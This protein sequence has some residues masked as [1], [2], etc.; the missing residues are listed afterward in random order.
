MDGKNN[1]RYFLMRRFLVMLLLV[2]A[3]EGI[4]N[5]LFH[6]VIYPWAG[7][8]FGFGSLSEDITLPGMVAL[9]LQSLCYLCLGKIAV[10]LPDAAAGYVQAWLSRRMGRNL[11]YWFQEYTSGL[12]PREAKLY[13]VGVVCVFLFVA[14]LWLLPYVAAAVSFGITVSRKVGEIEEERRRQQENYERQRNLLLSDVAHDLK[15]PMT[16]VAGYA[17]AL[18]SGT[19]EDDA[20][21]REYLEAIHRKS[22]QMNDLLILLFEYVKLDSEGFSLKK[23]ETDIVELLRE[24]AASLYTDFEDKGIQLQIELPEEPKTL[25]LDAMQFDRAVRNLLVNAVKHNPPGTVAGVEMAETEREVVLR[26]WDNGG[27]VPEETA[28][29]LFEPFVQGDASRRSKGG[30]GLG[31]SITSKIVSMH[32]GSICLEQGNSDRKEFVITLPKPREEY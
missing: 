16:T 15:T 29:H 26:I 5:L 17:Q 14:V 25:P 28:A 19:V 20:K 22:M 8:M 12:S 21:E 30:S 1:L 4:L 24:A 31:L 9:A 32:G 7:R 13:I 3:A 2:G 10:L 23:E 27:A 18:A 11:F 6:N